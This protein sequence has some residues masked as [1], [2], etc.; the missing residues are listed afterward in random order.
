MEAKD[1]A[2][3]NV[4]LAKRG[5]IDTQID[6]FKK[7]QAKTKN[8]ETIEADR[9]GV[10]HLCKGGFP[11]VFANRTQAEKAAERTGGQAYQSRLSSRFLV[12]FDSKA[13]GGAQ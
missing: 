3:V 5:N 13:Q 9:S 1:T 12:R 11:R 10:L 4:P 6:A 7:A 8:S 2:V